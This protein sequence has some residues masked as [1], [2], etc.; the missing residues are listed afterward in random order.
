M[1]KTVM[2]FTSS[3]RWFHN[4][5]MFTFML[6]LITGLGMLYFNLMGEQGAPRKFLVFVHEMIALFFIG[7]PIIAFTL[8]DRFIW[9]ENI[10]IIGVWDRHDIEWLIK[11]PLATI[12]SRI[13]LPEEDKFNPG[14][15]TWAIFAITTVF[16]LTVTG[17]IMWTTGSPIAALIIHTILALL[18]M[19]AVSG[20]IFMAVINPDTRPGLG[21]ILD[22][23]VDA[24]WAKRHHPLWI[25]RVERERALRD[26]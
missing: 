12:S 15:K 7:G 19:V 21:S 5:V 17:I 11:K 26:R 2:R 18:I 3:E 8:G 22:G 16:L 25:E 20:H 24:E 6:L 13:T 10:R 14:Q 4:T 1:K 23:E 9:K